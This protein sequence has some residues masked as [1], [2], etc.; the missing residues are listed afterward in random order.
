MVNSWKIHPYEKVGTQNAGRHTLSA[1]MG[2]LPPSGFYPSETSCNSS[3]NKLNLKISFKILKKRRHHHVPLISEGPYNL[4]ARRN[5]NRLR[6]NVD[7][8]CF[9]VYLIYVLI[10]K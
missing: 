5:K 8:S 2:K 4:T 6:L 7:P 9:L 3:I 1:F 10:N